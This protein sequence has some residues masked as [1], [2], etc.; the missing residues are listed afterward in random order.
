MPAPGFHIHRVIKDFKYVTGA[1]HFLCIP[2]ATRVSRPQLA[3]SMRTL[4]SDPCAANVPKEAFRSLEGIYIPVGALSLHTPA[5]VDAAVHLVRKAL[6]RHYTFSHGNKSQQ[7]PRDPLK[8]SITG[9]RP[10]TSPGYR[11]KATQ[12]LFASITEPTGQLLKLCKDINYDLLEHSL[13]QGSGNH[14]G[15]VEGFPLSTIADTKKCLSDKLKSDPVFA[16]LGRPAF[17]D[18]KIDVTEIQR[19]YEHFTF[20]SQFSLERFTICEMGLK[21]IIR[22]DGVLVNQAY[23]EAA[24]I[25]LPGFCEAPVNGQGC[26]FLPVGE[27]ERRPPPYLADQVPGQPSEPQSHL[28]RTVRSEHRKPGSDIR[29][30]GETI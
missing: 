1:T 24:S 21:H 27:N 26:H 20:A 18:K 2:L 28:F 4:A 9:L 23:R 8:V 12:S 5:A 7:V 30:G 17:L 6:L 29:F 16:R 3:S 15:L 22:D 14:S 13:W 11:T 25:P 10:F 19:R